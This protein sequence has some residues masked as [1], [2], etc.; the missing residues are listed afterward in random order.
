MPST[1]ETQRDPAPYEGQDHVV[2]F[3]GDDEGY[4]LGRQTAE[5]AAETMRSLDD[6]F[7]GA[8]MGETINCSAYPERIPEIMEELRFMIHSTVSIRPEPEAGFARG[9][10]ADMSA[11]TAQAMRLIDNARHLREL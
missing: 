3:L 1:L 5:M 6:K 11:E 10:E 7:E 8:G 2:V 4:F 9:L